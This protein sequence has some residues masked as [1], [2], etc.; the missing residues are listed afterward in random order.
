MAVVAPVSVIMLNCCYV[1][2]EL[3]NEHKSAGLY[4]FFFHGALRPQKPYGLLEW[5]REW[6]R[7]PTSLF[8]QLTSSVSSFMVLYIHRNRKAF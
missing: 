2:G 4:W 8:T 6:G 7:R 3:N 1:D 5:D